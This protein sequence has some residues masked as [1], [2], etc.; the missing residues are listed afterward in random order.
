[1]STFMLDSKEED[2]IR[3]NMA[4]VLAEVRC[5]GIW[6]FA[7]FVP[8]LQIAAKAMKQF[9][10]QQSVIKGIQDFLQRVVDDPVF[11]RTLLTEH[12]QPVSFIN[13]LGACAFNGTSSPGQ[14]EAYRVLCKPANNY[15][16]T[17]QMLQATAS[18]MMYTQSNM[19][20]DLVL[21]TKQKE[22]VSMRANNIGCE[23]VFGFKDWRFH[24]AKMELG[25]RTDGIICWRMNKTGEWVDQQLEDLGEEEFDKWFKIVTSTAFTQAT[26]N[27]YRATNWQTNEAVR[28]RRKAKLALQA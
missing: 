12:D 2:M 16:L 11:A 26:E 21:G 5:M 1:M 8:C 9:S 4:R 20:A 19:S 7:L 14:A 10:D 6:H 22:V 28:T 15:D 25:L 3:D 13:P 23:R 27:E 17:L 24:F 18:A